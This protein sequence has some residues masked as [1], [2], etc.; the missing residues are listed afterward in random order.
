V[1]TY[2]GVRRDVCA[3]FGPTEGLPLGRTLDESSIPGTGQTLEILVDEDAEP[4]SPF[5]PGKVLASN[6][7][8][9]RV[10][11][12]GRLCTVVAARHLQ[13]DQLVAIKYVHVDP[14][15]NPS[16][17]ARFLREARLAT[18]IRSEHSVHIHDVQVLPDGRAY[19]VMDH[20]EGMDLRKMLEGG[21]LLVKR[22]IDYLLQ[23][24]D[25]IAEAHVAGVVHCDLKPENVFLSHKAGGAVIKVLDFGIATSDAKKGDSARARELAS[26]DR[27]ATPA[28]MAPE[29]LTPHS[30]IDERADIWALGVLLYELVSGTLPFGNSPS[31]AVCT[32]ITT[33]PPIPL[34]VALPNAPEGLEAIIHLCLAKERDKRYQNVAELA[35]ALS[36]LA[37]SAVRPR[38]E[39]IARMIRDAGGNVPSMPP[40][41][42]IAFPSPPVIVP[43]EQPHAI[44]DGVASSELPHASRPRRGLM[45]AIP[46]V[47]LAASLGVVLLVRGS[48]ASKPSPAPAAP[49]A[50]AGS[51]ATTEAPLVAAPSQRP[52]PPPQETPPTPSVVQGEEPPA[53]LSIPA[54]APPPTRPRKRSDAKAAPAAASPASAKPAP[55]P[56][57]NDPDAVLNPFN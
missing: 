48:V 12:R 22:A 23:A 7:R 20:L 30:G 26:E 42:P 38:I 21:P 10:T 2:E 46:L 37:P 19:M 15:K 33:R 11:G 3:P 24:C 53:A 28:Y 8:I 6:Y 57:P 18:K 31:E 51:P 27:L 55:T 25:A 16:V 50:I 52:Q 4:D 5:A 14:R 32:A 1:R 29:Q 39:R 41:P 36:P 40:P 54:V 49:V 9:D 35:V 56:A 13:L 17:V 34:G 43:S 44:D 45:K 47:L